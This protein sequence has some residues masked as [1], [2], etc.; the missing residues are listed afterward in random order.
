ME[1]DSSGT[2]NLSPPTLDT[3]V[4]LPPPPAVMVLTPPNH[5][6]TDGNEMR[7]L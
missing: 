1:P 6:P 4:T 3:P 7:L 2:C 5:S